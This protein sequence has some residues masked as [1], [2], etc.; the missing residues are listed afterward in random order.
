MKFY[1]VGGAV[2]DALLG[3]ESRDRDYVV[4]GA[5]QEQMLELG[6]TKV[7]ADFPVFLHPTTGEE[8]ALARNERK[9]GAGYNGFE[10]DFSPHVTLE[11]DLFR[12]D[13]TI[14]SMAMEMITNKIVDPYGGQEDLANKILRHTSVAFAEDPVRVLR[15]ARF[16]ARYNDF[17]IH[18]DTMDLMKSIVTSG[19][20]KA[21][22]AERVW[23]EFKKGL[24]ERVPSKMIYALYFVG[25]D[26]V[27]R[28]W[29]NH[30][31]GQHHITGR[32]QAL[33][34]AAAD[35]EPLEV[36]FAI[37]AN[38]FKH[39]DD[40]MKWTVSSD[41]QEVAMLVN[42]EFPTLAK[43]D[44]LGAREKIQLFNRVDLFRRP[45]RFKYVVRACQHLGKHVK[46]GPM[47]L[48]DL[49]GDMVKVLSVPVAALAM[50]TQDKTKIKDLIFDARV[51]AVAS[52]L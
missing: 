52:N 1:L 47:L 32:T 11:E 51:N 4:V 48:N 29:F 43:Y 40:Y 36:R 13:L 10:V 50:A 2:R 22:T 17:I 16:F 26:E 3:R 15:I 37:I 9:V 42:N 49:N 6:Y 7:G 31:A 45:D 35:N 39:K 24:M 30:G 20:F 21:L 12:R 28:E 8:Y 25:A 5:T 14:N 23:M 44:I 34:E 38:G 46:P 18:P 33:D 41:C 19:E 27:L